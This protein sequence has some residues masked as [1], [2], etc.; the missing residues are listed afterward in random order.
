MR[1]Q[2]RAPARTTRYPRAISHGVKR[3][4]D[5]R[6]RVGG[7]FGVL[8]L[9]L[10]AP[11]Q[12]MAL[13]HGATGAR[14]LGATLSTLL[15]CW[16]LYRL[17]LDAT[18]QAW[19]VAVSVAALYVAAFS[20]PAYAWGVLLALYLV[21]RYTIRYLREPPRPAAPTP[22]PE[23]VDAANLEVAPALDPRFLPRVCD[24]DRVCFSY[25]RFLFSQR[26]VRAATASAAG[27]VLLAPP[28]L[29]FFGLYDHHSMGAA[30][31]L[32]IVFTP[33]LALVTWVC[34]CWLRAL[35]RGSLWAAGAG[36]LLTGLS[37]AAS[38]YAAI[39]AFR[40]EL[41]AIGTIWFHLTALAMSLTLAILLGLGSAI[42]VA[43]RHDQT[44]MW[45]LRQ[46]ASHGWRAAVRQLSGVW[47]PEGRT[48]A[49]LARKGVV[50]SV[51][52]FAVEGVAF[53]AY[54]N[55]SG[56]LIKAADS[57]GSAIP[58][59]FGPWERHYWVIV[60]IVCALLPALYVSTQ[61]TLAGAER[62]RSAARRASLSPAD[63][64]V[65]QDRRPPVLFLR[66]FKDDQ[67]SLERATLPPW[68][69]LIDPGVEQAN[70]EDVLQ[71]CLSIGPAVAI[72]R[73]EDKEPPLGAARRYVSGEGWKEVVQSMM[74]S[75]VVIVIGAA[76]S[77]GVAWEIDQ[78]RE[79]GHLEKSIFVMPPGHPED[80]R[81]TRYLVTKL[82]GPDE[83]PRAEAIASRLAREIGPRQLAGVALRGGVVNAFVTSRRPSQVEFDATLRLALPSQG[84]P[85]DAAGLAHA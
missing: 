25:R 56:E 8:V 79:R 24:L 28:L 67:V 12:L 68:V 78:L 41:I 1:N 66:D 63:E 3:L 73:P 43:R 15:V 62:L 23:L 17:C 7:L 13:S 55:A 9:V 29:V 45:L 58:S 18:R 65:K 21:H 16:C 75:A 5:P 72:G 40:P 31:A 10:V 76:A 44:F 42:V 19:F 33:I 35:W 54:F 6:R 34:F 20:A 52:A 48:L 22:P 27:M 37:L 32:P 47:L 85:L 49:A 38:L 69:R 4:S 57:M 74:D 71:A 30:I 59:S 51:L 64:I 81:L 83:R 36:L 26:L 77:P 11:S 61:V 60:T 82:V 14:W 53:Y 46:N 50:L 84:H 80:H 70:L 39:A 2:S